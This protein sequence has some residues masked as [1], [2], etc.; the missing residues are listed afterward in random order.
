MVEITG[1]DR[2]RTKANHIVSYKEGVSHAA[3]IASLKNVDAS[4]YSE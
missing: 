1:R 3:F 2:K 4:M